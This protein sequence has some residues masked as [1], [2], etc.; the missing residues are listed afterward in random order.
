MPPQSKENIGFLT[1]G[2]DG[3]IALGKFK[4]KHQWDPNQNR[5]KKCS[6]V[7]IKK[8]RKRHFIEHI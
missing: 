2:G 6:W 7:H 5:K 3:G 1:G 4:V 8:K